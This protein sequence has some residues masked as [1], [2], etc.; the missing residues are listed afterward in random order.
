MA[1]QACI[2]IGIDRYQL[3]Q[4]LSF[5]SADA[6]SIQNFCI[7]EAGWN[8]EQCLLMTDNSAALQNHS[9][10]PNRDNIQN[11]LDRWC[12]ETLAAGDFLCFFFSGYGVSTSSGEYLLPIDADP[13]KIEQTGL[14]L[15]HL[16]RQFSA[17]G[18]SVLVFLDV[19]RS[20]GFNQGFGQQASQLAKEF[21]IPTFLSCQPQEF[22][23]EAMGL[24][25]SIFTAALLEALRF[26]PYLSFDHLKSYLASRVP[27]LSEHHWQPTQH[28]LTLLPN[29]PTMLCPIFV[30]GQ[31][32][33]ALVSR[34]G[35]SQ[36]PERERRTPGN[37]SSQSV[38]S[39][40]AQSAIVPY[41]PD[42]SKKQRKPKSQPNR[43]KPIL[44]GLAGVAL[45]G[46]AVLSTVILQQTSKTSETVAP[47]P[48]DL[49]TAYVPQNPSSA[50][51]SPEDRPSQQLAE[52]QRTVKAGDASSYVTAIALGQNVPQDH[53][54]YKQAQGLIADW[55]KEIYL[56][57]KKQAAQEDWSKAITIAKLIPDDS[58]MH[59]AA[60]NAIRLWEQQAK[61]SKKPTG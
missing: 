61:K 1:R 17:P 58:S 56:L 6:H 33:S 37:P 52:A 5:A 59:P 55:A 53:P 7:D 39:S 34:S 54:K 36:Q 44:I 25:H 40:G 11:L 57:A 2:S 9:T 19:N 50:S 14:S 4:P 15:A 45:T 29:N 30:D 28:P 3:F 46:G 49:P 26:N 10:L 51:S 42:R 47:T 38:S 27:E 24:R 22:S 23:H 21:E 35:F 41:Q 12:W 16:Y 8:P 18:I 31:Q 60:Q 20:G 13:H 43:V 48:Q 32:S